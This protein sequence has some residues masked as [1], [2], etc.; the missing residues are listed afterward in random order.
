MVAS[1]E[2]CPWTGVA[3]GVEHNDRDVGR[4][5]SRYARGMD[6]GAGHGSWGV[7]RGVA[8]DR[9]GRWIGAAQGG[10]FCLAWWIFF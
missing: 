5:A 10:R 4:R 1:E 6:L 8:R 3:E 2:R 7:N 9:H